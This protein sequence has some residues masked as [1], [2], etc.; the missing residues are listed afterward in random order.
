MLK[1]AFA[2]GPRAARVDERAAARIVPHDFRQDTP[3]VPGQ[4]VETPRDELRLAPL[5]FQSPHAE[6]IGL[7]TSGPK[8]TPPGH[9]ARSLWRDKVPPRN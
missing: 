4:I 9:R 3:P 8:G 2:A 1:S 5:R 6:D 7:P